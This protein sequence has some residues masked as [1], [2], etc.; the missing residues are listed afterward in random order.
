[1]ALVFGPV[2]FKAD[3]TQCFLQCLSTHAGHECLQRDGLGRLVGSNKH[4]DNSGEELV[5]GSEDGAEE[6]KDLSEDDE[7]DT[8]GNCSSHGGSGNTK[9]GLFQDGNAVCS[10]ADDFAACVVTEL[11]DI[12]DGREVFS[13][14]RVVGNEAVLQIEVVPN[15]SF[16]GG[17]SDVIKTSRALL[18][19]D[20]DWIEDIVH[21]CVC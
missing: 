16:V 9:Q 13:N 6:I 10:G 8:D 17:S 4:F 18:G 11:D 19:N 12:G 14:D 2:L 21:G 7:V 20:L 5:D 3:R 1:M 15:P